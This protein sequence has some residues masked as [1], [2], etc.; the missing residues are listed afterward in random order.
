MT[1]KNIINKEKVDLRSVTPL[2]NIYD[3]EKEVV[4]EAEMPGA[5]KESI[6]VE[7]HDDKLYLKGTRQDKISGAAETLLCERIP[8]HYER[9]FVLGTDID[10]DSVKARFENGI[11]R[12]A[13]LKTKDSQP[14][15]I[16]IT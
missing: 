14:R 13:L 4:L 10:K 11:L 2:V 6:S 16:A 7:I 9:T 12:V 8:C 5:V 1:I 15:K 3:L